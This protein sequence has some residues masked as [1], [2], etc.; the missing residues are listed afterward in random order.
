MSSAP[1]SY[2]TKRWNP[3]TGCSPVSAGCLH[4][5]ARGFAWRHKGRFGY[6]EEEPFAPTIHLDRLGEPMTWKAPQVVAVSFM[7]D[8]FHTGIPF[9]FIRQM[10]GVMAE[11]PRHT[12]L[13]LT[14]RPGRYAQF[15]RWMENDGEPTVMPWPVPNVWVGMSAE[16]QVRID[17]LAPVLLAAPAAH[18]WISMEPQLERVVLDPGMLGPERIAWVVQGCESGGLRRPFGMDWAR[19]VRDACKAAFVPYY[20]KQTPT[21]FGSE[22]E[23]I[24]R[25]PA[26][27]GKRH[28]ETPWPAVKP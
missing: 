26:L 19:G 6:P 12:Y 23:K 10:F 3:T 18:R 2:A 16:T 5:W 8:L 17:L 9:E 24:D 21:R 20:L 14:K 7:G 22:V 27:A 25:A 1:A 13:L 4:C 11:T 28:A 15:C